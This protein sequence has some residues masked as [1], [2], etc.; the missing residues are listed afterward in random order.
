MGLS[1][2]EYGEMQYPWRIR[3]AECLYTVTQ[4][5]EKKKKTGK[6]ETHSKR[7]SMA[8]AITAITIITTLTATC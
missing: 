3:E 8:S 2:V 6:K 5:V 4:L 1:Q 7:C